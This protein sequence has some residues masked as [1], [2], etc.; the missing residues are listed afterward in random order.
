MEI[1]YEV[2]ARRDTGLYNAKIGI[3]LFL[4]SEVM[5]FGGLFSAYVFLRVGTQP[6]IDSPWPMGANVQKIGPGFI[7][8]LVLIAS[9][10]FVV[11]AWVALKERKW[12]VFQRWMW[13]VIACAIIFMGFKAYEYS[14]KLLNHHDVRLVDNSIIGGKILDHT[15]KIRFEAEKVTV[16]FSGGIPGFISQIDE[17]V[18]DVE[19]AV[20]SGPKDGPKT[21]KLSEFKSWFSEQ[22]R[23]VMAAV[24]SE[25]V[26]RRNGDWVEGTDESAVTKATLLAK[27]KMHANAHGIVQRDA[28]TLNYRDRTS[29]KGKLIDDSIKLELHNINLQMISL[30]DQES[31]LAWK[32]I[33]EATGNDDIKKQVLE[34]RD[35][36]ISGLAEHYENGVLPV[37]A[38]RGP[39][40]NYHDLHGGH[41]EDHHAGKAESHDKKD[42][43][44]HPGDHGSE[45]GEAGGHHDATVVTIPRDQARFVTNHGPR[46]GTYYAIYFTMTGLHGLHVIGG[47]LVLAYFLLFGKRIYLKNPE[48]LANRVEVGGLFWHFVDLVWIF[49]FPI[50]YLM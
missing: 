18:G 28:E 39:Y 12:Q 35:H 3:W 32:L 5:L 4:A 9:S 26:R 6:G 24:S 50:M 25:K 2:T 11:F 23:H 22:R 34:T 31:V 14:D 38:L 43:A 16:D 19:F 47:A 40:V 8:T 7:N 41:G 10:V 45:E 29:I 15:D 13:G 42:A 17:E 36:R 27:F 30:P 48:H 37:K 46:A 44:A 49:L 1:P 33:H 21:V 20:E